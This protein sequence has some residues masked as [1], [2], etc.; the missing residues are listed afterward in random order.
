M[1]L[2]KYRLLALIFAFI[3]LLSA[4]DGV[5]VQTFQPDDLSSATNNFESTNANKRA[6]Q[7][8]VKEG[9]AYYTKDDVINYLILYRELPVNYYTKKEARDL[10]WIAQ[11]G[12]LWDVTDQGVIGGDRFGN[13]EGL[14]PKAKGRQYFEADVDY[15]GGRR[16]AKRV[17]YSN[18]GL[19]YYTDDHYNSFDVIRGE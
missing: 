18:D 19:I 11:D 15:S 17:V 14:L 6:A 3:L 9:E 7:S 2:K 10:G 8:D 4:C 13:R 16:N 12:N 1:R 5:Q